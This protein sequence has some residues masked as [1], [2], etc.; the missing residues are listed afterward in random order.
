MIPLEEARAFV[1]ESCTALAPRPVPVDDALGLVVGLPVVATEPVPPFANSSRDGYALRAS[2]TTGAGGAGGPAHLRVVGTIMAGSDADLLV[3]PGEAARIMTGA[4][5]PRGADAVCMLEDCR[6]ED[7]GST[8]VIR[9]A[10]DRDT[11]VRHVGEDVAVGDTVVDAGTVLTPGHLG[12]LANQ[13]VAEV[14]A[15]PRL[16]VGVLSTGDELVTGPGRLGPGKIRDANRHTLLALVRREGWDAVD[17]GI[18]RDDE[19]ALRRLFEQAGSAVD[20]IVCSGGVSVGDLDI[21]KEVLKQES[22]GTM[23]WMQVAIRPA[24]PFAFGTLAS[25]G[26][27]VFGL[28]GNPVSAMVSFELFVRPAGLLMSG[29]RNVWRTTVTAGA[30]ADFVRSPDG[31]T[32]YLRAVL[33]LDRRGGW[34]VRPMSGQ[35]SHQLLAMADANALAVLPDGGG[36]SAQGPVEVLVTDFDRVDVVDH[37]NGTRPGRAR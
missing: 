18:V 29:R 7:G 25:S 21:V 13:G 27:P 6:V 12:V 17:L 4:P 22:G 36:I 10:V 19:D 14:R 2:D 16:R 28:P 15:H 26:V 3:G 24:K 30:D 11:A 8:L 5:L 20:A 33:S 32:H 31:K 34:R 35:D 37:L 1:M 9:S 23:R